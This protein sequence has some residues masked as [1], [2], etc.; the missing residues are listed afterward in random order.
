[1]EIIASKLPI[2][3]EQRTQ[4]LF[5][6]SEYGG[7]EGIVTLKDVVDELLRRSDD[8]EFEVEGSAVKS[9]GAGVD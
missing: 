6:V 4:M 3:S 8:V 5:L 9:G 1:M 2:F 7:V